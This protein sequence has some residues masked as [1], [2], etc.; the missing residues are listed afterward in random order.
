M[1][2][3]VPDTIFSA[4]IWVVRTETLPVQHITILLVKKIFHY[5]LPG[6][7]ITDYSV[8]VVPFKKH[9]RGDFPSG[10]GGMRGLY[11]LQ[12]RWRVFEKKI[13]G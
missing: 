6:F 2:F 11:H 8:R 3:N 9:R 13:P 4:A 7:D 5:V 12:F 1:S 10:K